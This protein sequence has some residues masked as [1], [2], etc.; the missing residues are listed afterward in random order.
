MREER[1]LSDEHEAL[2]EF[3]S[4][5]TRMVEN[6]RV[7]FVTNR[8]AEGLP[9]VPCLYINL[10][11]LGVL[12]RA[13]EMYPDIVIC[14]WLFLSNHYHGVVFTRGDPAALKDFMNFVD[15]EIG[16]IV[17]RILGKRHSKI[18]AQ[19]YHA[20]LL[21]DYMAAL[22]QLSYLYLNPV[23][24]HLVPSASD[25][26]GVTSYSQMLGNP[27][28]KFKYVPPSKIPR[29]PNTAL[30]KKL[31]RRLTETIEELPGKERDLIIEPFAWKVCFASSEGL[32]DDNIRA[33]LIALIISGEQRMN[34][35][36]RK[37]KRVCLPLSE[38]SQQNPHRYYRPNKF[39]RRVFCIATDPELRK[40]LIELYQ[41]FCAKC[42]EVWNTWKQGDYSACYPPAAF[43]PPR[44]PP[45]NLLPIPL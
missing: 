34:E 45:A 38:L 42:R 25:W 29:L 16:K 43:L 22:R 19:R 5:P 24:A 37:K 10:L 40:Q 3:M 21:G 11:I 7:Y 27:A 14:G 32:S 2:P 17:A 36:R 28:G 39:G 15:G 18:W 4:S 13:R 12:A 33:E 1:T 26:C 31:C 8:L 6:R 23:L 30:T 35:E 44:K 9:F 20:A 41:S